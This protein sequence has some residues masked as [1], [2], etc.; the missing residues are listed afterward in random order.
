MDFLRNTSC[1]FNLWPACQLSAV[2]KWLNIYVF[3]VE[4]RG[5][6]KKPDS[7][8][9]VSFNRRL[10][11]KRGRSSIYSCFPSSWCHP[12]F[13][14]SLFSFRCLVFPGD[15]E[16]NHGPQAEGPRSCLGAVCFVPVGGAASAPSLQSAWSAGSSQVP[17]AGPRGEKDPVLT[18]SRI[19]GAPKEHYRLDS[20]C[21][22]L[23]NNNLKKK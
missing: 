6:K 21:S 19:S 15:L 13:Q 20:L 22:L 14:S 2:M 4:L 17:M 9:C 5:D 8:K 3:P 12:P 23:R 10:S 1:S 7:V 11:V 18:P 16:A